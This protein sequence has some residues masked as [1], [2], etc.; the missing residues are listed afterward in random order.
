MLKFYFVLFVSLFCSLNLTY[1]Q[2]VAKVQ[3]DFQKNYKSEKADERAKA[4]LNLKSIEWKSSVAFLSKVFEENSPKVLVAAKEVLESYQAQQ[5]VANWVL[6]KGIF[7]VK[8]KFGRSYLIAA[9]GKFHF[10]ETNETLLKMLKINTEPEFLIPAIEAIS[11]LG[12]ASSIPAL[13]NARKNSIYMINY[14]Y[15]KSVFDALM[16]FPD[17]SVIEFFIKTMG[18]N[19]GLNAVQIEEYLALVTETRQGSA[20]DWKKWWDENKEKVTI[21]KVTTEEMNKKLLEVKPSGEVKDYYGISLLA[22]RIV[23]IVDVSGSMMF[24]NDKEVRIDVAK[25]EL[26]FAI[27]N[28][29]EKTCIEVIEFAGLAN[30]WFGELK[31]LTKGI[32]T[33]IEK[34]IKGMAAKGGTNTHDSFEKALSLNDNLE[35]I[36]FMSDGAPSLG[37]II[38]PDELLDQIYRWN[39]FRKVQIHSIGLVFGMP[40]PEFASR[41]YKEDTPKLKNF[42]SQLAIQNG[43]QFKFLE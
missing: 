35:A 21:K 7:T 8:N 26:T 4:V 29:P 18:E 13:I 22:K 31:A 30:L 27:L 42:L 16:Q 24:K 15:R 17:K 33:A 12:Y 39:R 23:F 5:E 9:L 28:L 38:D 11:E 37:S 34:K 43:G 32:K 3:L 14:G 25:R 10:E 6:T 1:A 41:G 36:Y 2:S 19:E 20:A 40:T